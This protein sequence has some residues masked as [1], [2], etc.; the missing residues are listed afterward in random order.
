MRVRDDRTMNC[1][2]ATPNS[3]KH[4]RM[5]VVAIVNQIQRGKVAVPR[6][7]MV[8][9][10]HGVGKSTFGSMADRPVFIQTEDGLSG[11]DCERFPLARSYTDVLSA[12]TALYNEQHE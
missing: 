3:Q 2:T 12:M 8:Y 4:R 11:I 6:R 1:V 10:T 9:G 5:S 7:V